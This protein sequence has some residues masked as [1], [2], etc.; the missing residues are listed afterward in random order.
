MKVAT[1]IILVLA[2]GLVM[3]S[4]VSELDAA[5]H[6]HRSHHSQ[7]LSLNADVALTIHLASMALNVAYKPVYER[8]LTSREPALLRC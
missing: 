5:V 1:A 2:I 4:P 3:L 8:A 6:H 7:A